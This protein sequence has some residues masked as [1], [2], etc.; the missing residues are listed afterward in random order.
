MSGNLF[1]NNTLKLIKR[2]KTG[3]YYGMLDLVDVSNTFSEYNTEHNELTADFEA[4]K[5]DWQAVGDDMKKSIER[6]E[7]NNHNR[8]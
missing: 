7:Q 3:F 5:S 2:K 6:Y 8:K 4:I 1:C